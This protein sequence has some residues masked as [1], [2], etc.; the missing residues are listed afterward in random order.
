[1]CGGERLWDPLNIEGL[2]WEMCSGRLGL[3]W[4]GLAGWLVWLVWLAGWLVGW[5]GW[6]GWSCW[7]V[8]LAGVLAEK[9]LGESQLVPAFDA[10]RSGVIT[11]REWEDGL[12]DVG[13]HLSSKSLPYR[14]LFR[15]G[16]SRTWPRWCAVEAAAACFFRRCYSACTRMLA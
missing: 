11:A 5:I 2:M 14:Q 16:E 13:V 12:R 3:G 6:V 10:D 7:L 9:G 15:A 4:A 8:G 1:M